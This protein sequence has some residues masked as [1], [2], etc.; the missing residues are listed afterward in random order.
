MKKADG[1]TR[2]QHRGIISLLSAGTMA[3]AAAEIG[4]HET[5]LR[6][7][8]REPEFAKAL[9]EARQQSMTVALSRLQEAT[10]TAT[11]NLV[12]HMADPDANIALRAAVSVLDRAIRAGELLDVL[13]RLEALEKKQRNGV[14]K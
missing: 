10:G 14:K 8:L 13:P 4:V 11:T 2:K 9:A 7:W 5:T 3:A 6:R 12:R 1:L